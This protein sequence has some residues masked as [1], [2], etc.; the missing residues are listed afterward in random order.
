MYAIRSYYVSSTYAEEIK[1][2]YYGEGLEHILKE[3]AYKLTGIVNGLDV[4]SFN[5]NGD[6]RIYQTYNTLEGKAENKRQFAKEY[7]LANDKD[8]I[9]SIVTRLDR[10]KG[11]DLILHVFDEMMSLP[12]Q[13]A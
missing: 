7:H 9:I 6:I 13:F 2:A 4:D 3:N 12:V 5:P 8:M 11:L 10:Q 1:T